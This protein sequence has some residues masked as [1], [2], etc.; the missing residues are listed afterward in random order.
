M[1]ELI[2]FSELWKHATRPIHFS[3][4]L[5]PSKFDSGWNFTKDNS[6]FHSSTPLG[7]ITRHGNLVADLD[8]LSVQS[9]R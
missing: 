3:I 1:R 4:S 8:V 6:F 9:Y 2:L 7:D 5:L